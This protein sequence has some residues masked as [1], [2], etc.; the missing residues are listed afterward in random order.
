[1]NQ[2]A[3]LPETFTW[4]PQER[5]L[6]SGDSILILTDVQIYT[7]SMYHWASEQLWFRVGAIDLK[8]NEVGYFRFSTDD[9][10]A[11]LAAGVPP[12]PWVSP[13]TVGLTVKRLSHSTGKVMGRY[14]V[15]IVSQPI[16]VNILA[17]V[18]AIA[19]AFQRL[20]HK[21]NAVPGSWS[22]LVA[23][24]AQEEAIENAALSIDGVF[25]AG[26]VKAMVGETVNVTPVLRRLIQEGRLL[27]VTRRT[28]RRA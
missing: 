16:P 23:A 11:M 19:K 28:Y 1:M 6:S 15:S 4:M 26:D 17:D 14:K 5:R 21:P 2:R 13:Q 7:S 27:P 20:G 3:T 22:K 9:A 24:Q 25:K 8:T 10:R 18:P 12:P